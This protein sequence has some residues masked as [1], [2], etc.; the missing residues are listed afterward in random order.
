M[1]TER[2]NG[3]P[4]ETNNEPTDQR[5][6]NR[7]SAK[8]TVYKNKQKWDMIEHCEHWLSENE[9]STLQQYIKANNLAQK[10]KDY[11]STSKKGWR[12]PPTRDLIY[13]AVKDDVLKKL[14]V[15]GRQRIYQA[16]YPLMEKALTDEIKQRRARK[17]R[18][19]SMW[20]KQRARKLCNH[21]YGESPF[22]ASQGWLLRFM[23]HYKIKFQKRKNV[24]AKSAD[25][26][27]EDI[28]KWHQDLR[29]KVLPYREGHVGT[30]SPQYGR[31]PPE[32]RY[33]MDQI[34]MPFV[35]DQ[36]STFTTEDDEHVHIRGT[37][38]DGLNKRQYSAHVFINAGNKEENTHGYIDLI[39][40]GKGVRITQLEKDSYNP[41]INVRWQQKAWVDREVMIDIANNFVEFKKEKHGD[42]SILLICDNLDAHCCKIVLDIFGAANILVWFCVPAC[43]DLV[44]LIDAGIGR[45]LRL[46]VGHCLDKWL[47]IEG[48]LEA[49]EGGLSAKERRIL[50]TNFLADAMAEILGDEKKNVRIGA[51]ARTGCLI[52]LQN[53]RLDDGTTTDDVIKPQGLTGKYSIPSLDVVDGSI[54]VNGVVPEQRIQPESIEET[55]SD[56]E[57]D[58]LNELVGIDD[59]ANVSQMK[60]SLFPEGIDMSDDNDEEEKDE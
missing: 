8:R 39:C 17:A 22:S 46:S 29:Y 34:P 48:N 47:S 27:R 56:D 50:M 52:E 11:L 31:F 58:F 13:G 32:R 49:W 7:G 35:V 4:N 59:T 57:I 38:A 1:A 15:P 54:D 60:E 26:K 18:V 30:F 14:S 19:S 51:F 21:H 9:G 45:S 3:E 25:E 10:M 24:K 20:I 55:A 40:R 2:V 6:N 53:R 12:Y 23:K 41:N 33:N 37:G 28:V 43:T 16:K 42:D 5:K 36:D 44:Q